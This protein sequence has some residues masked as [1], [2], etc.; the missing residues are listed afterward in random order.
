MFLEL[1]ANFKMVF[2]DVIGQNFDFFF[3]F[4]FYQVLNE[5]FFG[6]KLSPEYPRMKKL[7]NQNFKDHFEIGRQF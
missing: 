5:N 4:F 7:S 1:S 3:F 6:R 2:K